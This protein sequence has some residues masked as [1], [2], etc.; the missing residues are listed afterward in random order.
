MNKDLT[1][2]TPERTNALY[3]RLDKEAKESGYNLNPDVEFTRDLVEGLLINEHRYGYWNCPCRRATGD[4]QKDLD[5]IC[6][7]D[8]RDPDLN[9][10]GACFC[11]LYVSDAI[12][13][14]SKH[15]KP[16]PERRPKDPA[17]RGKPASA[18]V[19]TLPP[20]GLSVPVWRCKVC[21]YLCARESP[22]EKCPICKVPKDRFERFM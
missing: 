15:P 12:A 20:T 19:S 16:I 14:G 10:Y 21:G 3:A 18:A 22:P 4:R 9:E 11:A 7:C 5:M 13:K 17:D 8:Y 6:P 1:P 2:P